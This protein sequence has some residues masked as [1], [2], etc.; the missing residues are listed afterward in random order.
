MST[1]LTSAAAPRPHLQR[2]R[3]VPGA[4]AALCCP[5]R[6]LLTPPFFKSLLLTGS[7]CPVVPAFPSCRCHW[8]FDHSS[9]S[10]RMLAMRSHSFSNM[11]VSCFVTHLDLDFICDCAA[12]FWLNDTSPPQP[13]LGFYLIETTNLLP[14]LKL[15]PVFMNLVPHSPSSLLL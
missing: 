7:F 3:R 10:K 11:S 12:L 2:R 4:H 15:P 5:S 9:C 8:P 1:Y 6:P 13:M 14:P